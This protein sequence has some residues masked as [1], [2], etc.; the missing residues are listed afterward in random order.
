MLVNAL[1]VQLSKSLCKA[2]GAPCF[3]QPS[4]PQRQPVPQS[5][6]VSFWARFCPKARFPG[7]DAGHA[8]VDAIPKKHNKLCLLSSAPGGIWRWAVRDLSARSRSVWLETQEGRKEQQHPAE[9]QSLG[10]EKWL[11]KGMWNRRAFELVSVGIK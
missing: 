3:H 11:V 2:T 4:P 10:H 6:C 8:H 9:T 5:L 1:G 7:K